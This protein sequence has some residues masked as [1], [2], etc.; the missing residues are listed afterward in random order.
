MDVWILE[1]TQTGTMF[2]KS[3]LKILMKKLALGYA[4]CCLKENENLLQV[5][6]RTS[7]L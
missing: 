2:F 7:V 3:F 6:L 5:I 4:A 1:I